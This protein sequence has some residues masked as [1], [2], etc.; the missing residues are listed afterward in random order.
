MRAERLPHRRL[1]L[2]LIVLLAVLGLF[3]FVMPIPQDPAYHRFADDRTLLGIPN[4]WNV[5]SNLPFLLVGGWGLILLGRTSLSTTALKPAYQLFFTGVLLTAFGSG[6]Y[7]LEPSNESLVFDRLSMT[8]SFAGLFAVI[9][10][11]FVSVRAGRSMLWLLLFA[12][13]GSVF[14]W[15]WTES[16]GTGDLRPYALVQFL[17]MLLIPVIVALY[18]S[19][20][21][22]AI[23]VWTMIL[24]YMAAKVAELLDGRIMAA[25]SFISG[26]T[27][28]HLFAAMTPAVLVVAL[29]TPDRAR[30]TS[31]SAGHPD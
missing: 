1:L 5:L 23:T 26:H 28:K 21:L 2:G 3:L 17:P 18:R 10:G 4:A 27:I 15:A 24:F 29:S 20:H 7:H 30:S 8:I 11:E 19:T 16:Q 31:S 6:Y 12:G 13:P 25:T 22:R 9:V 14:Y